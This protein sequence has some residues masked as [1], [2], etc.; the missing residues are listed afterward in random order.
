[1]YYYHY[2]LPKALCTWDVET[3]K[4]GDFGFGH[5][6]LQNL[7]LTITRTVHRWYRWVQ[8]IK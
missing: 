7:Q 3:P 8:F 4:L 1:M 2:L 5:A 6:K